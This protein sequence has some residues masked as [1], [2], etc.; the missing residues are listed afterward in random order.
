MHSTLRKLTTA[1][2]L[3]WAATTM[4]LGSPSCGTP[5][6]PVRAI[7]SAGSTDRTNLPDILVER[8]KECMEFDGRQLEPGRTVIESTVELNEDRDKVAVT[9]GGVPETARDFGVCIRKVLHDMPIAEQ[10]FREAVERLNFHRKH[11][12][13]SDEALRH[14]IETIPGVPIV[15]SELVLEADGYTIVLPVTVKVVTKLEDLIDI[16]EA[17]LKK[18]GQMAL[19]SLGYDEIMRQA[20]LVGWVKRVPIKRVQ[21]AGN[22]NFISKGPL[23]PNIDEIAKEA[24][25][26][27]MTK[28]APAALIA[29]QADTFAPGPGDLLGVGILTVGLVTVGGIVVYKL[30]T[31][32]STGTTTA[33]ASQ[34]QPPTAPVAPPPSPYCPRN[35]SF[36][37]ERTD[38]STGCTDKKG[39]VRCYSEKH[40]PCAGVHT[41]GMLHYQEIR[42]GVCTEVAKQAVRCDG[43]FTVSGPCGSVSTVECGKGGPEISGTFVKK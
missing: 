5:F 13:D 16:D 22:K 35:E 11:A 26:Q 14:F 4:G 27:V 28:A 36:V 19:D 10:P 25:K 7:Q 6:G 37:P 43:P 21:S 17:A 15:E 39:N 42:R 2:F 38:N 40:R 33:V 8:T 32:S 1:G 18:A 24:F 23:P 41:H 9:V 12:K 30:V 29:S 3:I 20:E 31:A 34:P